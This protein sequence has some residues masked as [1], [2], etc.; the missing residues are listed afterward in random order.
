MNRRRTPLLALLAILA[1]PLASAQA[2]WRVGIGIGYPPY[3]Y[4]RPYHYSVVV[5]PGPYYYAPPGAVYV[6]AAPVYY[7]PPPIYVQPAP[8]YVQPA[9]PAPQASP[10]PPAPKPQ[11]KELLPPPQEVK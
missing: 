4:Y 9:Q 2:G 8:V 1:L 3:P 11:G 5:A 6:Q 10:T 7:Y